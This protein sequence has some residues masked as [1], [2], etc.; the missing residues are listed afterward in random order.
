MKTTKATKRAIVATT[1]A[2]TLGVATAFSA[3][4]ATSLAFTLSA[5]VILPATATPGKNVTV[6]ATVAGHEIVPLATFTVPAQTVPAT[7][8]SLNLKGNAAVPVLQAASC[9]SGGGVILSASAGTVDLTA[10]SASVGSVTQS[11]DPQ[12]LPVGA[13]NITFC[14]S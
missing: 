2:A 11:A 14:V 6:G 13:S 7:T 9:P 12:S 10:L 5:K 1:I 3:Q 4:A 8:L